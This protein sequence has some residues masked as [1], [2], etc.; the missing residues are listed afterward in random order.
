MKRV[1]VHLSKPQIV[2]LDK[3]AK[4]ADVKKSELIR[5][6]VD[7]YI[8]QQRNVFGFTGLMETVEVYT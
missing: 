5:R 7:Q 4:K 1:N 2:W 3:I 6:A 8:N